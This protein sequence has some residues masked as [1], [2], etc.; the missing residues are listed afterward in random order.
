M[1]GPNGLV[2]GPNKIQIHIHLTD[3]NKIIGNE[4][5]ERLPNI[6]ISVVIR[7]GPRKDQGPLDNVPE[8][9]K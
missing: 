5:Y 9:E 1:I 7:K 2:L 3:G 4:T 6:S 8:C